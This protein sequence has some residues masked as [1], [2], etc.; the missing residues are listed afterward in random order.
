MSVLHPL[1]GLPL[2]L[3]RTLVRRNG[4]SRLRASLMHDFLVSL[5]E[6]PEVFD[7]TSSILDWGQMKN[8]ALGDCTEAAKGHLVQ[9]WTAAS[10]KEVTLSDSVIE[11]AYETECGY[12]SGDSSTDNG[13]DILTVLQDWQQNGLGGY[14]ITSHAEV[15]RTQMRIQQ[16]A[17][18][19]GGL[20]LGINLP[21]AAQNQVGSV[22]DII[23]GEVDGDG[24][25]GSWG[26]HSVAAMAYDQNGITVVTWGAL[27]RATWRWFMW[28]CDEAHSIISPDYKSPA[29]IPSAELVGALQEVGS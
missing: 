12:V 1:T 28:Y 18:I 17:W 5:P 22:W 14:S 13:G 6:A 26:G 7:N 10:G 21:I 3:G 24:A 8:D 25:A 2:K 29:G 20:D 19:F 9:A 11:K 4:A 27:Q 23:N 16:A 15:N